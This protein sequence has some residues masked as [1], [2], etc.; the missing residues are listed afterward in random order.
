[1]CITSITHLI[2]DIAGALEGIRIKKLTV[3]SRVKD[4]SLKY[5][6]LDRLVD[7]EKLSSDEIVDL[8][9]KAR[10]PIDSNNSVPVVLSGSN[11][12][13]KNQ[14]ILNFHTKDEELIKVILKTIKSYYRRK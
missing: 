5:K 2:D 10:T 3:L 9:R 4:K 11:I 7:G 6:I 14:N 12:S 1:M 13:F 8:T